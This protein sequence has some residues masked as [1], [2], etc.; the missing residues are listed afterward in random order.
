MKRVLLTGIAGFV[1]SHVAEHL[2]LNTDWEIVGLVSFRH[3]GSPLRVSERVFNP[4]RV[5]LLYHDL[6][7]PIDER[8]AAAIGPID[9][10]LNLAADSHVDRSITHPAECIS[11]NVAVALTM[12]EWARN[13]KPRIFLQF[14]TDEVYGPAEVGRHHLEWDSHFPSNPYSASKACQEDIAFSY[15][16][17]FGIPLVITNTMN[18]IGERQDAEK[19]VPKVI[20][21]VMRGEKMLIHGQDGKPGSRFYI[22]ARN[23]ADALL[24]L[25]RKFSDCQECGWMGSHHAVPSYP[26]SERPA[27]FHVV[28]E[29]EVDNLTMARMIADVIGKPLD[30]EIVNF[31]ASR[32]GHDLR[33]AL[34]GTKLAGL[35]WKPPVSLERSLQTTVEWTLAHPEWLL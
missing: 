23:A 15:W 6:R 7:G 21:S 13:A 33:Y 28:G 2:L 14:S 30:Y 12:L 19:F 9:Y 35:G 22:H 11:N 17:T 26:K 8:L 25:L 20:R 1:G 27:R 4:D 10:V 5:T 34:D 31:H 16:R 3:K 29:R 18:V 32:P 24:Y